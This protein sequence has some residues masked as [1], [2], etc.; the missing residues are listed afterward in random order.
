MAHKLVML[1]L[2]QC[3]LRY[4]VQAENLRV[5]LIFNFKL[6]CWTSIQ[7]TDWIEVWRCTAY[8]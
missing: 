2:Q 4:I 7:V 6:H 3:Q 1:T 5:D 8:E